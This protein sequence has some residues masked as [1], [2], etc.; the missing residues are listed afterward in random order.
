MAIQSISGADAV[1]Q[2]VF[3]NSKVY[4]EESSRIEG[5]QLRERPKEENKGTRIDTTA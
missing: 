2:G 1:P 5:Q 4:T 3:E